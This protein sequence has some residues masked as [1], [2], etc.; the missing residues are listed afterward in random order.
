MTPITDVRK[1]GYY[2]VSFSPLAKYYL[3]NYAGPLVPHQSIFSTTDPTFNISIED[4]A[5]LKGILDQFDLPTYKYG[6]INGTNMNY[7]EIRPPNFDGSGK[8]KYPVL[9]RCYGGPGSQTVEM[10]FALDW[11]EWIVSQPRLEYLVVEVDGRGTGFMGRKFQ[12]GIRGQ[13]GV[14]ESFDQAAAAEY[15]SS[16]NTHFL[17]LY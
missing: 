4:N 10:K 15:P 13:L 6:K 9:F 16:S 14:Q 12:V 2:G 1:D 8:V 5:P 11:H 3:L 7:R 17:S